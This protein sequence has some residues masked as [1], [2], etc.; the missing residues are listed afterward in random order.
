MFNTTRTTLGFIRIES[1]YFNSCPEYVTIALSRYRQERFLS[2][3]E[4]LEET[5]HDY[6]EKQI[7]AKQ[8]FF[9]I[10]KTAKTYC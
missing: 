1:D 7:Y 3:L 9:G 5:D 6:A 4:S 2:K 8:S 10:K